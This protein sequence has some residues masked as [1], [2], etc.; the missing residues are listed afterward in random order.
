MG[1][2]DPEDNHRNHPEGPVALGALVVAGGQAAELLAAGDQPLHPVAQ[3]VRRTVEA[4]APALGPQPGDGV[5]GGPP[6]AGAAHRALLQR[7]LAGGGLVALPGRQHQRYR[8][9]AALHAEMDLRAEP[10]LA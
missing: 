5:A 8:L 4:A 1:L 6:P 2:S 10:A 9:A 3:A 7:L